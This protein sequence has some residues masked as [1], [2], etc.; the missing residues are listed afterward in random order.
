MSIHTLNEKHVKKK[1]VKK[2]IEPVSSVFLVPPLCVT[3]RLQIKMCLFIHSHGNQTSSLV[4]IEP[5]IT[6]VIYGRFM[7]II[8][9]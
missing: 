4:V 9:Y 7:K 6:P 8:H 3:I 5:F 1:K 2:N